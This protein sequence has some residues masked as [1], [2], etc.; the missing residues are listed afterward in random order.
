MIQ[1]D[2]VQQEKI[3]KVAQ[4]Y[5]ITVDRAKVLV[6]F[7]IR[8][9]VRRIRN[10][11]PTVLVNIG[12]YYLDPHKTNG[13]IRRLIMK[14]RNG[15]MTREE[16]YKELRTWLPLHRK[17]NSHMPLTGKRYRY[18]MR[19]FGENWGIFKKIVSGSTWGTV[20]K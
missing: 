15:G 3:E 17:A 16:L 7:Y 9:S 1:W 4:R 2:P 11:E 10:Y 14:F 8:S 6:E 5:G 12:F 18:N 19:M 13:K 20:K